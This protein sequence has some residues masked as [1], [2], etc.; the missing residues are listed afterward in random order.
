MVGSAHDLGTRRQLQPGV[1]A[2]STDAPRGRVSFSAEP[3]PI[4]ALTLASGA[5]VTFAS[6][7]RP[8]NPIVPRT[9]QVAVNANTGGSVAVGSGASLTL[10]TAS[11]GF[12]SSHPFHLTA[13]ALNLG[14]GS[15]L[16]VR[17]GSDVVT[18]FLSSSGGQINVR[19]SSSTLKA[20]NNAIFDSGSL[21][22]TA[23]GSAQ[24]NSTVFGKSGV[25]AATVSD[26]GSQWINST[27]LQI[28]AQ[29]GQGTLHITAGGKVQIQ[30]GFGVLG[31][32]FSSVGSVEISGAGSQWE[33]QFGGL[34]IGE[35]GS[36]T[37]NVMDGGSV[38]SVNGVLGQDPDSSGTATITDAVWTMTGE[39]S[40]GGIASFFNLNGGSGTLNIQQAGN[41]SA[42][43]GV[44]IFPEGRVR[45][46]GGTLDASSIRFQ[47]GGLFDWSSGTLHVDTYNGNLT[48]QGGTLAPGRSIG[49]TNLTGDYVQQAEGALEV[50][51]SN[52]ISP[53]DAPEHDF[54][55][56][57]RFVSLA[58]ELQLKL[59][60]GF[61][62]TEQDD[63]FTILSAT[64]GLLGGFSNVANN[65]RLMTTDGLGSFLVHYGFNSSFDPNQIVLSN[66]EPSIPGDFD[67]DGDVDGR[68]FL[69]WQRG[70]SPNSSSPGDLAAWKS[71]F[72]FAGATPAT[73]AVPEPR[74]GVLL[75]MAGISTGR[76][77]KNLVGLMS[78]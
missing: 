26:A 39:L 10:G 30:N 22:V 15:T 43:Q 19:G 69:V 68:D 63:P 72:G 75:V 51:I 11:G 55:S 13:D 77:Q 38:F 33:N 70:G 9:L 52:P 62:P 45:L 73:S 50:E 64:L 66:F 6:S 25:A 48:N 7:A 12:P 32:G 35:R 54:V 2:P 58:G 67:V 29:G 60:D 56:S 41:V 46:Q 20:T 18:P 5:N 4:N 61:I 34:I 3:D 36:G 23:G 28:G 71:N 47:G 49:S 16:N 17:F 8:D 37:L 24:A 42:A 21:N 40:V 57:A 14:T 76:R 65:Q 78:S 53:G 44:V 59:I 27:G 31:Y 1:G 74:A